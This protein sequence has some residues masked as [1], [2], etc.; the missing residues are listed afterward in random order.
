MKT[1]LIITVF[2]EEKT[3]GAFLKSIVSQSVIPDEIIIVDGGSTDQTVA[4]IKNQILN[5]KNKKIKF[6]FMVKKGNRAVGRNEAIKNANGDVILCSDAGCILD[7]N[8][9]K[10]ITE[11]F[12]DSKTDVV[13]GYYKAKSKTIFEKCLAPYVLVMEDRVV[14]DNFLPA[15]RSMAFKKR[16]WGIAGKFSE[17]FSHN[18]D[19]VF[20]HKLKKI[21]VNIVFA[22]KAIVYWMPR[23]NIKEAFVMFFRF[24]LGDIEANIL[25]PKV[26]FIFLRYILG[27]YLLFL[28]L[29]FKSLILVSIISLFFSIYLYYS[30]RKNYKYVK[31]SL[32]III[33]PILQL[34]SDL[35][36]IFGTAIGFLRK[37]SIGKIYRTIKHNKAV[38][39]IIVIYTV[40]MLLLIDW[41]IPNKNHPFNYF[42]DEW[43]QS[44]AIRSVFTNGSPNVEGAANGTMLHFL[45]SGIYLLP[46][47]LLGFINPFAIKSSVDAL[48]IQTRLFEILR[49]NTL[50]FGILSI[51]LIVY[52]AKKY[53]NLNGFLTAF[54][55]VVNPLFLMLSNYFKYDIALLFWILLSFLM[56]LRYINKPSLINYCMAAVFTALALS[57]KISALPLLA[58]LCI[59][60]F[61]F[62]KRKYYLINFS[63]GIIAF[64]LT[65]LIFGIPDLLFGKGNINEYLYD[66][67][68]RS[69]NYS[70]NYIL[71]TNYMIYL[72]RSAL[73]IAF[74][75]SLFFLFIVSLIFAFKNV[76]KRNSLIL[77]SLFFFIASLFFLKIEARG[78]RLLVLLPF[79]TLISAISINKILLLTRGYL[80]KLI[81]FMLTALFLVQAIE[82]FAWINLKLK[83]DI[84]QT[85]SEWIK[86]NIS[87][88]DTIGIE[89]IPIYQSLPDIILKDYY[90]DSIAPNRKLYNYSIINVLPKELPKYFIITNEEI[91]KDYL[92]R[93]SKKELIKILEKE[94]YNKIYSLKQERSFYNLFRNDLDYFMSGLIQSPVS[95]SVYRK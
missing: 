74:G 12:N 95:V 82:S 71:G 72:M 59:S 81:I 16:I 1:S 79:I 75:Y 41:G 5:I 39:L 40:L 3:I 93:S 84:R 52:I 89:N 51:I 35:A 8:W 43:H 65:L 67:L 22:K 78:N 47:V 44:Q 7:K 26:V 63:I 50:L 73:P 21:N 38:S 77:M 80:K 58:V 29:I 76:T 61:I 54:L 13:A 69:P 83:K 86:N 42:M 60:Y 17:E 87:L 49:L 4:K 32:G 9:V 92:V 36:V 6:K 19:Y 45:L 37:I 10:N 33:L 34:V 66:N 57:V 48:E 15:T 31:E 28:A 53:F 68:I 94:N 2:N 14:Q 23:K 88:G 62:E 46:F 64:F 30:I 55:F 27:I 85:S 56:L 24:A 25:R 18:E 91:A 70:S 11:P 90:L 20:A